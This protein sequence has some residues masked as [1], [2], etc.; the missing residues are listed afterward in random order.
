ML[1]FFLII[2]IR[3]FETFYIGTSLL[4]GFI[5]II[6]GTSVEYVVNQGANH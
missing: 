6:L 3:Y 2:H 4:K 1:F 5:I